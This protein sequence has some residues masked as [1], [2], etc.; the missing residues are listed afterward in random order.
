MKKLF[1]ILDA[2]VGG[3]HKIAQTGHGVAAFCLKCPELAREWNNNYIIVKKA[4]DLEAWLPE[5]DALFSEPYWQN[6]VTAVAAFREE[7]FAADLPLA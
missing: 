6:R 5:A 7:G 2:F 1:I 4:K 3:G